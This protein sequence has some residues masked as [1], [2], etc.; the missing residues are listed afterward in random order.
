MVWRVA[1]LLLLATLLTGCSS[2]DDALRH[3][4]EERF[5]SYDEAASGW[6]GGQ[7]PDWVPT[8]STEIRVR[9]T[10]DGTQIIVR[11]TTNSGLPDDCVDDVPRETEPE[12]TTQWAPEYFADEVSRCGTY[13]VVWLDDGWF[14]WYAADPE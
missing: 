13:E 2:L 14:G 12:L 11:A 8:D 6:V 3:R 10:N 9:A 1:S 7:V 4:H 5:A